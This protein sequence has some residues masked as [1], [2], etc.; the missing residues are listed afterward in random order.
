MI[1]QDITLISSHHIKIRENAAN[2]T[3]GISLV[4]IVGKVFARVA[5][6]GLQSLAERVYPEVQYEFIAGRSI[7]GIIFSLSQIEEKCREQSIRS[8]DSIAKFHLHLKHSFTTVLIHHRSL[9]C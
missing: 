2:A 8:V 9:A 5:L 4:S 1:P 7:F 3:C 6:D